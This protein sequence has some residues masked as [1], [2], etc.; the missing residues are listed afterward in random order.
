MQKAKLFILLLKNWCFK[1]T[2]KSWKDFEIQTAGK[3]GFY[4]FDKISDRFG[5]AATAKSPVLS[6][7]FSGFV[8]EN[9]SR[10][11]S[12]IGRLLSM[13]T[14]EMGIHL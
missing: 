14:A 2:V 4:R 10:K 9:A 13:G 7:E 8:Y 1:K 11:S 5:V 12:E 3:I 6:H